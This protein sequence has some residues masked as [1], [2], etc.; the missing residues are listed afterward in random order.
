MA[1]QVPRRKR[2]HSPAACEQPEKKLAA[3]HASRQ[4]WL[5]PHSRNH[6]SQAASL[7]A[8]LS[9]SIWSVGGCAQSWS[10]MVWPFLLLVG[11][12]PAG[13]WAAEGQRTARA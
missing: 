10:G 5:A 8:R 7:T 1:S 9:L 3:V 6:L 12:L 4:G 2:D 13:P 11:S